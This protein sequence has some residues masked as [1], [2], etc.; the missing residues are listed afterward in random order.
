M[1]SQLFDHL[2]RLMYKDLSIKELKR[3]EKSIVSDDERFCSNFV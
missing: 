2:Y 1:I 3:Y